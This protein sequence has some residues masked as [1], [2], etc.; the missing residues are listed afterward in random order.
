[1]SLF[2]GDLF[3]FNSLTTSTNLIPN[4]PEDLAKWFHWNAQGVSTLTVTIEEIE[5][6]LRIIQSK[7]RGSAPSTGRRDKRRAKSIEIPHYPHYDSIMATEVQGVRAFGSTDATA[8]VAAKLAEKQARLRGD[9]EVTHEWQRAG[10]INGQ[11]LDADGTVL[12][13]WFDFF[14][15]DK[16]S[17]V[18]DLTDA[19]LDLRKELIKAK[20]QGEKALGALRPRK[21]KLVCGPDFYLDFVSHASVEK[22]Y[23]RFQDGS[24]LRSDQRD[25]GLMIA[26]D[27]EV[28]SYHRG[29]V[30]VGDNEIVFIGKDEAKLIPDVDGLMQVRF[31]PADTLEAA[32]TI[33][34]PFYT[35]A[36]PK[37][38]DRGVDLCMESNALHYLTRIDVVV[39]I[40]QGIVLPVTA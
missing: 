14:K 8:T 27:I 36:E 5:G 28:I 6:E 37:P 4:K 26:S 10:A 39:H 38:F 9:H 12:E 20:T 29:Y 34:L 30:K 31:A 40:T 18:L 7:A 21:W 35:S 2:T 32:N 25:G 11:L 17:F 3:T 16:N 33:G 1:M 22:M 23:D 24:V 19:S 13:D 15:R